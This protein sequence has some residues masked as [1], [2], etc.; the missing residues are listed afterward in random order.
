M[1]LFGRL[2]YSLPQRV[3]RNGGK[4]NAKDHQPR[5]FLLVLSMDRSRSARSFRGSQNDGRQQAGY[6]DNMGQKAYRAGRMDV[7]KRKAFRTTNIINTGLFYFLV[8]SLVLSRQ[9]L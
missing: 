7:I 5:G 3:E 2:R 1:D 9:T 4:K 6:S 8:N